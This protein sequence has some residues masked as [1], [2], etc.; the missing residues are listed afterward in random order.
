MRISF[1]SCRKVM[2]YK[3]FIDQPMH[4]VER[5][6]NQNLAKKSRTYNFPQQIFNS[7]LHTKIC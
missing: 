4:A 5:K 2:R 7:T 6:L 3:Y 1:V